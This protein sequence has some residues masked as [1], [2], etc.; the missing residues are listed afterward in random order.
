VNGQPAFLCS[1]S[2]HDE[3]V[4]AWA[5]GASWRAQGGRVRKCAQLKGKLAVPRF[6]ANVLK[7]KKQRDETA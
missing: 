6:V 2:P 5:K 4:V 1:R 7:E 3:T